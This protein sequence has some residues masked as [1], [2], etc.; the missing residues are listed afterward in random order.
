MKKLVLTATII[1]LT[2]FGAIAQKYAYID[3]EYLLNNIPSY[4]EAQA[5]LDKLSVEWQK[6]IEAKFKK[7]DEMYKKYQQDVVVLPE[8][9]KQKRQQEIID[10][11]KE[12]KELQKKRFGTDGDLFKKR[13]ELVK[14]IQDR[15]FTAIE[16]YAREKNYA[17]IFDKAGDLTIV[18][19][20]ARYD[21]NDDILLKLG[22]VVG[23]K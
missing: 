4:L 18:Y 10:A 17:F 14:P 7:I 3:S 22:I 20:D 16:E 6:E 2:V 15:V 23:E 12:A 9:T 8:E 11:E 5:E 19:A 1:V 13:E 21:I